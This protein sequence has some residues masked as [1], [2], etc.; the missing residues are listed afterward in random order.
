MAS[1]LF[2]DALKTAAQ[3]DKEIN[4]AMMPVQMARKSKKTDQFR[5]DYEYNLDTFA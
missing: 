2:G 1:N 3:I 5:E 4:L